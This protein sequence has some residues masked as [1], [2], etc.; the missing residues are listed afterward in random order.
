MQIKHEHIQCVLLA[1]AAEVGQ[2][3]AANAIV[4]EYLRQGGGPLPLVAGNI[5][6]NQQ[7]IF[8]RWL[9]GETTLQREKIRQLL[10]AILGVLP[11][12]IRHHLSIYD[13]IE[14]RALLAAQDA[15]GV[16]IDAHDDAIESL[17]CKARTRTDNGPAG[18]S[19]Y[20]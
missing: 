9:K 16:A 7:Y 14:R 18:N 10:P 15:L 11:R 8:H 4:E 19:L 17:F 2:A 6:N 5:W 1:W 3:H 13:T 20:H 12:T